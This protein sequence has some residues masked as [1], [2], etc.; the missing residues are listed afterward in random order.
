MSIFIRNKKLE[1]YL[2]TFFGV[3]DNITLE[4]YSGR[5]LYYND[6]IIPHISND[7]LDGFYFSGE[8]IIFVQ[9]DFEENKLYF[10]NVFEGIFTGNERMLPYLRFAYE[11]SPTEYFVLIKDKTLVGV[12]Y[13]ESELLDASRYVFL[14]LNKKPRIKI[15]TDRFELKKKFVHILKM[16]NFDL[17]EE[18]IYRLEE[19]IK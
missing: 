8:N 5:W 4:V 1:K 19:I 18:M 17:E 9:G 16:S 3:K 11:L 12:L 6:I 10:V 2:N 15:R 14:E 13:K 7:E